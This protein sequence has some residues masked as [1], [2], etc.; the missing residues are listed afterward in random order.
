MIAWFIVPYK[1]RSDPGEII[2]YCAMDDFTTQI[3]ADGGSWSESEVLG[4][5]AVVKVNASAG[6]LTTIAGTAGFQR[7]PNHIALTDTLGDLTT[8][9]RNAIVSRLQSAGYTLTEIRTVMPSGGW[10]SVTLAQVLRFFSSRR[11]KPRYDAATDTIFIDGIV[12]SC[13][14]I[15]HVDASV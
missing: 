9:Q 1:R 6:T 8:A 10:A 5:Q 2:R 13:R 11:L 3:N 12:Q 15:E 4:D 7:I 14:P